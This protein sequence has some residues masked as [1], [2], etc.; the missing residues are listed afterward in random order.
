MVQIIPPVEKPPRAPCRFAY[1]DAKSVKKD[2]R[3]LERTGAVRRSETALQWK[4]ELKN[5][6]DPM[7][8]VGE[9]INQGLG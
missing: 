4:R 9:V 6:L 7:N 3:V 5:S 8:V 2:G 1:I